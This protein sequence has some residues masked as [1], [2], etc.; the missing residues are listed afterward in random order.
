M[1]RWSGRPGKQLVT[2]V[3]IAGALAILA[4]VGFWPRGSAPDL[5]GRPNDYVDATVTGV[6]EGTCGELAAAPCQIA[7]A[8]LTSGPEEGE[9]VEFRVTAQSDAPSLGEG[10]EVVLLDVAG[11][12]SEYRYSFADVQRER[13]LIW[14]AA[15]FVAIVVALGR[16]QGARALVGLAGAGAVVAAFVVPALLHDRPALP[17]ALAGAILIAFVI[18]YLAHGVTLS[19]TVALA[20]SIIALALTAVGAVT[21]AAVAQLSG[22]ADQNADVLRLTA[23][24]LDMRGLLIAGIVIGVIG[25]LG[26]VTIRQVT[27]VAALRRANPGLSPRLLYHGALQVGRDHMTATV[28]TL[29][30]AYAGASLPLILFFTQGQPV[31]RLLTSELISVEI[32][33]ILVGSIALVA[34]VPITTALAAVVI[35]HGDDGRELPL[36]DRAPAIRAH[37]RRPAPAVAGA[38]RALTSRMRRHGP[39]W[40]QVRP[41]Q[42]PG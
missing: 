17:V 38:G 31:G 24:S 26:D 4:L 35:G 39:A 3:S 25:V 27:T 41:S 32:V 21:V 1:G 29:V 15:I 37:H 14:L 2:G 9:V 6:D 12:P 36:H 33:R 40:G 10:A 5:G 22:L 18:L 42:R 28:S 30:L 11:N 19:T 16:W 8:R 23:A 13:P 34:S 20:G 7:T